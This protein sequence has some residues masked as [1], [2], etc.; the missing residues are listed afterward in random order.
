MLRPQITA[1]SDT[2]RL[3]IAIDFLHTAMSMISDCSVD[4]STCHAWMGRSISI[5]KKARKDL[6][7]EVG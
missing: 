6:S 5:M 1:E 4:L 3:E 7:K 2:E